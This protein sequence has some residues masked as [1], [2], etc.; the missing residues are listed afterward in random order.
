[1][2]FVDAAITA[3]P[4]RDGRAATRAYDSALVA[5][6]ASDISSSDRAVARETLASLDDWSFLDLYLWPFFNES[7]SDEHVLCMV[8]VRPRRALKPPRRAR[9]IS[10]SLDRGHSPAVVLPP[11]HAF[12][13]L[14]RPSPTYSS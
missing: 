7:A 14:A 3:A 13:R 2:S 6:V 1:M 8:F 12:P 9:A 5:R 11:P 10:A 4:W